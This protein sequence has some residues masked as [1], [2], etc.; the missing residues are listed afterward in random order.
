[1]FGVVAMSAVVIAASRVSGSIVETGSHI[2]SPR[3]A[4]PDTS[5]REIAL[6]AAARARLIESYLP[7]ARSAARRYGGRGEPLADLMQVA[8]IGL[9]KAVDRFDASRG[10]PFASYAIPTILGEIKRHFRDTTWHVRVPRRLQEL[11]LQLVTATEE[12]THA[13]NRVPT[14]AELAVRLDV[15][16]DSVVAA[17][18]CPYAYR[19]LSV[20]QSSP[21]G[22][23]EGLRLVDTLGG[24]DPDLEAVDDRHALRS[25]LAGLTER[26]R[27]I[28]ALRFI[29]GK[30]QLQIAADVGVSQMQVSRLLARALTRLR[31]TMLADAE[32][33]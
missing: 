31:E 33:R 22:G 30:T 11:R 23:G 2:D 18:C 28:I 21:G 16:E 9:I 25:C 27:Y 14:T 3:P 4:A 15:D 13:L 6:R 24:L 32:A 7:I 26:D 10:V 19:A 12:L 8:T 20:D 1:M 29:A 5:A 17:L